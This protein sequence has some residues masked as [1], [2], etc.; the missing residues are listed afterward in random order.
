MNKKSK[1][2]NRREF[3]GSS[4][5]LGVMSTMGAGSFLSP[6]TPLQAQRYEPRVLRDIA[7]DG[8]TVKAGLIGCGGRGTGAA[9]N[10]LN[11]GPNVEIIALGDLFQDRLDRCRTALKQ[12]R[13]V[14]V[15]DQN[16]FTGFDAYKRVLDT[17]VDMIIQATPPHFR[18]QHFAAAVEAKK[19]AF[20]EKPI[21]VDP[22]GVRSVMA[23]AE[24]ADEEG[25]SVVVGTQYRNSPD[26]IETFTML[27][28]GAIGDLV[29]A[30]AYRLSGK[31]W[32]RRQEAGES[33]MEAMIRD[34]VNW[35][36]LSGDMIVE[37]FIHRIDLFKWFFEK[38]PTKVIAFGGR[39]RRPTGDQYDFI[40]MDYEFDDGR[41]YTGMQRQIDGCYNEVREIIYG[42]KGYTNVENKIW[43]YD[44][45][46]IWEHEYPLDEQ[47]RPMDEYSRTTI[48]NQSHIDLVTAIRTNTPVNQAHELAASTLVSIM[49]REAS[50]TGD[51]ITWD[52]MMKSDLRLG[53]TEYRL[54]DVDI[55]PVAPV[56]GIGPT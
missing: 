30:N 13:D 52:D 17:D 34:W 8:P 29:S 38:D 54:G 16:C 40:S 3:I 56:P 2:I 28:N 32:H 44:D 22:V 19:H 25:L 11:S 7:S 26:R 6:S 15:P 47:G 4:A 21:A 14:D 45:N 51:L 10:F 9:Y 1:N 24:K 20:L 48:Q 53:P 50:Y 39:A 33:D 35:N 37:Q 43:D 41:K 42:T 49:G 5:V 18:P 36:W 23:T 12:G 31:L 46:L 55:E 27:K